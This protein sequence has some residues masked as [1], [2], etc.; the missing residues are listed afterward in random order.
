LEA[1]ADTNIK[2]TKTRVVSIVKEKKLE[3]R[4]TEEEP[5]FGE[6]VV[7]DQE[8]RILEEMEGATSPSIATEE[9]VYEE[10]D[11]S[12][13]ARVVVELRNDTTIEGYLYYIDPDMR[14][15]FVFR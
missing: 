4:S 6:S 3:S 1:M 2:T 15:I 7:Q 10:V 11:Y 8:E 9:E 14:F 5:H 12:E 13:R